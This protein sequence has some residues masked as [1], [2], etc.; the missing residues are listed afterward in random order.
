MIRSAVTISLVSQARGGPFV[1]WDDLAGS[2]QRAKELGFDAV[3][4]FLP[5]PEF[6]DRKYLRSLLD[7]LDLSVA[8]VGTGAGMVIHKLS[9][10]A[11][12]SPLRDQARQFIREM[13]DFGGEFGAPAIIGSMQGRHT[14][15]VPRPTALGYLTEA[16]HELGAYAGRH[17]VPL[18]YEPLNRYETNLCVTM[19]S[20]V[21]LLETGQVEN[22]KLLADLFHMNIEETSIAHG[23]L[24]AGEHLGHVHFVDSNRRAAGMGHMSF[25]PI[26]AALRQL[27]YSGYTSAE[28]F[29]FPDSDTAA[30]QTITRF[31]ELFR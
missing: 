17:A 31:R 18:I 23:L 1:Y 13:I 30:R 12:E 4:L 25:E 22:V 20:G 5:G 21:D 8:A 11:F 29:A 10:T 26:A 14:D 3:E 6:V 9:L 28:A 2:M 27:G 15:Q 19:E 7:E 24:A 16:L